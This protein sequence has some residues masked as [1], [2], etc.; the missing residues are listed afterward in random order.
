MTP[1]KVFLLLA[2]PFFHYYTIY[3]LSHN[4]LYHCP[5]IRSKK[6]NYLNSW[7]ALHK[8]NRLLLEILP[9]VFLAWFF[10]FPVYLYHFFFSFLLRLYP[11]SYSFL[12]PSLIFLDRSPFN[13]LFFVQ[14][15]FTFLLFK[16]SVNFLL[17]SVN[18]FYISHLPNLILYLSFLI[19]RKS[20]PKVLVL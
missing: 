3:T 18:V 15:M 7:H 1:N 11:V 17:L 19:G 12:Y 5:H 10:N 16:T 8:F 6:H 13:F 4:P 20:N 2:H 9:L 14:Q